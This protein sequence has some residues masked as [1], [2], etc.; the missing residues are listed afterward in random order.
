MKTLRAAAVCAVLA[1]AGCGSAVPRHARAAAPGDHAQ[2]SGR[3]RQSS[4]RPASRHCDSAIAH[5]YWSGLLTGVQFVSPARGWAVGQD[6]ILATADGGQRW[7]VQDRG[8]LNLTSVDFVNAEDG[9]AVGTGSLLATSDGGASWVPLREPCP[10]I[11]SVHFVSAS[12]GFAVAGGGDLSGPVPAVPVTGGVVLATTDGGRRWQALP[13]PAN[14]Q[15][16][17]FSGMRSGWLGAD[18]HLYRSADGGREWALVTAG[19]RP[20]S[21]VQARHPP[22]MIVQCAG[23]GEAWAEDSGPGGEMNQEPYI[24]YHADDAGAVPLFAEQYFPHPGVRVSAEAPDG[25]AGPFSAISATAAA[26]TGSCGACGPGTVSWDLAAGAGATL[27]R[28]GTISGLSMPTAASFAS[29]R[30]GWVAG[31]Y[32][33]YNAREIRI[34]WQQQ[35]IVVTG[36]GGRTWHVQYAGPRQRIAG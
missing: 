13:A 11:R 30:L 28:E 23:P 36:D 7:T 10:L 33:H 26:F 31:L 32:S 18:G 21:P 8:S 20:V 1:V 14:V 9:W 19:P 34:D 22:L 17:C 4:A 24:G 12:D 25:D 16:V 3:A 35:R 15:T 5:E 29:P 27:I 6:Q 2:P